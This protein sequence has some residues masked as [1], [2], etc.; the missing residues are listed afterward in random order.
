[1][2]YGKPSA[3]VEKFDRQSDPKDDRTKMF[4]VEFDRC[5]YYS[6]WTTD[7]GEIQLSIDHNSVT[8]CFVKLAYVDKIN[9][10]AIK[11]QALDDL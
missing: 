2:K 3:V 4:E 8:S 6:I 1:M 7:K 5:K 9:G 11:K 10:A